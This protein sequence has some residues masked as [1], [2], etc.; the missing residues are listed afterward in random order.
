MTTPIDPV[1]SGWSSIPTRGMSSNNPVDSNRAIDEVNAAVS[2][3]AS[4]LHDE[5]YGDG[6][7]YRKD[8]QSAEDSE[9]MPD[10]DSKPS[11]P[12]SSPT[13]SLD[14]LA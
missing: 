4:H 9:E 13:E 5:R 1:G 3:E 12:K 6:R 11:P 14:F 7:G 2:I 10:S 8:H